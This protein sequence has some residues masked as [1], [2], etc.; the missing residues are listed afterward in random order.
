MVTKAIAFRLSDDDIQKLRDKQSEWGLNSLAD[1]IRRLLNPD[2]PGPG[3]GPTQPD[4]TIRLADLESRLAALESNRQ[5][6]QAD[7]LATTRDISPVEA[8]APSR[9]YEPTGTAQEGSETHT[10]PVEKHKGGKREEYPVDV[11]RKAL[12]LARGLGLD[13]A[14]GADA[15]AIKKKIN[16][17]IRDECGRDPGRNLVAYLE[18]WRSK[19]QS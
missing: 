17:A 11:R 16:A 2:H 10:A 18:K 14:T 15:T 4:L 7:N 13:D 3:P 1:V 5:P 9:E 12:D 6:I 8:A 19:I